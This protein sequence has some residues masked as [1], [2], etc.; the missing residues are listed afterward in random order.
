MNVNRKI[1]Y[2]TLK[3]MINRATSNEL[4]SVADEY[5]RQN[6]IISN[7]EFRELRD[8]WRSIGEKYGTFSIVIYAGGAKRTYISRLS[9]ADALSICEDSNWQVD[10]NGGL[11]WD[12]EIE[13]DF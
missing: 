9:Y 8:L 2:E 7:E 12:M 5:L 4:L 6:E 3:G 13:E 1:S 11:M 10:Y